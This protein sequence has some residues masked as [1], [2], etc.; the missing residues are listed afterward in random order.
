MGTDDRIRSHLQRTPDGASFVPRIEGVL[1]RA[2]ARRQRRRVLGGVLSVVVLSGVG[3]PLALLFGLRGNRGEVVATPL[4]PVFAAQIRLHGA[5]D[6]A[7]TEDAV[8]VSGFGAVTRVD[9]ATNRVV[10]RIATPGV[11]DFS[12]IAVGEGSVWV[13]ANRGVVYRIDPATDCVIAAI[14]AGGNVGGIAAG[15]GLVWVTQERAGP[16]RLIRI[17]PATNRVVGEPITVGPGPGEMVYGFGA[18]WVENTS[19]PSVMRVDAETHGVSTV[20]ITGSLAMGYGSVWAASGDT[21]AR[22]D[23]RTDRV[24]AS[25]RIPRAMKVAVGGGEVWVLASPR[26]SS[27]TLFYPI[28]GTAALWEVDPSTNRIVGGP[29][30]L[31]ALQP[32]ALSATSSSVWVADYNGETVTRFDLVAEIP[33]PTDSASPSPTSTPPSFE[34]NEFPTKSRVLQRSDETDETGE[35]KTRSSGS[36]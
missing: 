31:D 4:H 21:L 23:L 20:P 1:A 9:P 25:I 14:D 13:T 28:K 8:W 18:V 29:I 5:V 12:S 30:R 36:C 16:G 10:A 19:P 7:A 6:V 17:D 35:T 32:I 27:P 33:S 34:T 24:A 26:S 3:L 15:G 2:R 11:E 22:L